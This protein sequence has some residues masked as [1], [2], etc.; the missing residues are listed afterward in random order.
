MLLDR[1]EDVLLQAFTIGIVRSR[2]E[3]ASLEAQR[4]KGTIDPPVY[5][6]RR[7]DLVAE[8]EGLYAQ[9]E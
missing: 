3:L 7:A 9:I 4:R 6:S 5:A 1:Q 8:L 2:S